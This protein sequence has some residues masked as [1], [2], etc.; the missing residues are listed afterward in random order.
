MKEQT[1]GTLVK[2]ARL[3][4]GLKLEQAA[5][6]VGISPSYFRHLEYDAK[7]RLSDELMEKLIK[8]MQVSG[9]IRKL[10]AG[11]NKRAYLYYRN[12]RRKNAA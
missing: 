4:K 5:K 7:V 2:A 1:V 6:K 10:Q 3:K 9:Q 11:Y 12:Y 8:K